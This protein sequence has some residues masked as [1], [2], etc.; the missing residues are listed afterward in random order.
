MKAYSGI[1]ERVGE[2]PW[3]NGMT[4]ISVIKIGNTLLSSVGSEDRMSSFL[5]INREMTIYI[6]RFM[7]LGKMIMGVSHHGGDKVCIRLGTILMYIFAISFMW[8][9]L[10]I[11]FWLA[12]GALFAW[13]GC[14]SFDN[15]TLIQ[16]QIVDSCLNNSFILGAVASVALYGLCIFHLVKDYILVKSLTLLGK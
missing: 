1:L 3:I 13:L 11:F 14:P 12:F 7:F 15:P 10:G 5:D 6:H 4:K 9:F 2:G 16:Q 8:I